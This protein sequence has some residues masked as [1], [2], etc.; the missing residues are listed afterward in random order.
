MAVPTSWSLSPRPGAPKKTGVPAH[1]PL[2]FTAKAS[3]AVGVDGLL[4][5]RRAAWPQSPGLWW[6]KHRDRRGAEMENEVM[7]TRQTSKQAKSKAAAKDDTRVIN[8]SVRD[9]E[10]E[11]RNPRARSRSAAARIDQAGAKA[12]AA[13]VR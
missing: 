8:N 9:G 2:D 5:G 11:R 12:A 4:L 1:I 3:I 13:D 10:R 7:A 6:C